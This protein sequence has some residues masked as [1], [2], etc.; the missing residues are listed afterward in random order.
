MRDLGF[1]IA[2]GTLIALAFLCAVFERGDFL[3]GIPLIFTL[4]AGIGGAVLGFLASAQASRLGWLK[5]GYRRILWVAGMTIFGFFMAGVVTDSI[6][7]R[8]AFAGSG[9][10]AEPVLFEVVSRDRSSRRRSFSTTARHSIL[11]RLPGATGI[12]TVRVKA[13]EALYDEVGP[14]PAAGEHCIELPV[15][16]GR[17]GL[18]AVWVPNS[19]DKAFG[20]SELRPCGGTASY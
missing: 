4:I 20:P 3:E 11:V 18:R 10:R 16:T 7:L 5:S 6:A 15:K 17:W 13:T 14:G 2:Y 1:L 8:L 9:A 19:A 12:G